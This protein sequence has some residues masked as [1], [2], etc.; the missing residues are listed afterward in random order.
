VG[1][2]AEREKLLFRRKRKMKK[3]GMIICLSVVCVAAIFTG[4]SYGA[5]TGINIL[6]QMHHVWGRVSVD[7]TVTS[8]YD[9]T[10][11]VPVSGFVSAGPWCS[12][13]SGI[14]A[15][16]VD[17]KSV[18]GDYPP[19]YRASGGA[20]IDYMFQPQTNLLQIAFSGNSG[21]YWAT[22]GS[23][24][25]L[26]DLNTSE[27]LDSRS[28]EWDSNYEHDTGI[29]WKDDILPYFGNYAVIPDHIYSVT[30]SAHSSQPD[31]W[32]GWAHLEAVVTPEPASLLLLGLGGLLVRKNRLHSN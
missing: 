11:S 27:I 29:G 28:W 12:Q 21:I 18:P 16:M 17:T 23:V 13:S 25:E 30:I 14:G 1:F 10:D 24:F 7:G 15:F 19:Q 5:E 4:T 8:S 26:K 20:Q 2:C 22:G 6:S 32:Y 3:A 9:I 31:I